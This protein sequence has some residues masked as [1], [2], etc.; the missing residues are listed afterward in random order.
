[1][2][3]VWVS[4]FA[5]FSFNVVTGSGSSTGQ[6]RVGQVESV[7]SAASKALQINATVEQSYVIHAAPKRA[8]QSRVQGS[9]GVRA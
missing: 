5:R 4:N 9:W 8:V 2:L 1:M 3:V 6:D 7:R